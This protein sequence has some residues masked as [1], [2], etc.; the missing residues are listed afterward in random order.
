MPRYAFAGDLE[1]FPPVRQT[2]EQVG[3]V[4][5]AT[6]TVDNILHVETQDAVAQPVDYSL[7]EV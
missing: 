5:V 7:T 1:A 3:V 2:L 4:I 6:A